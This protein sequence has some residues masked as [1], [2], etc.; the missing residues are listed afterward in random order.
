V[1]SI[2][3]PLAADA[4]L[5]VWFLHSNRVWW[6]SEHFFPF[7]DVIGNWKHKYVVYWA[8]KC[9]K[10]IIWNK[11][12]CHHLIQWLIFLLMLSWSWTECTFWCRGAFCPA[13]AAFKLE[14]FLH[15]WGA[16]TYISF[17]WN[18]TGAV[19]CCSGK[20][21]GDWFDRNEQHKVLGFILFLRQCQWA[22]L[23]TIRH[24]F[25]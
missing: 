22:E 14:V 6:L 5:N 1:E 2:F 24:L 17:D 4:E 20:K 13:F 10:H 3:E 8:N 7:D 16:V 19:D 9:L 18:G 15:A 25:F 21:F 23:R 11:L 12:E